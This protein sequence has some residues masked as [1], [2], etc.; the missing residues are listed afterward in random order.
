[1]LVPIPGFPAFELRYE[2]DGWRVYNV[3]TGKFLKGCE[4]PGRR[5]RFKLREGDLR[6]NKSLDGWLLHAGVTEVPNGLEIPGFPDYHLARRPDGTWGVRGVAGGTRRSGR[7]LSL[8]WGYRAGPSVSLGSTDVEHGTTTRSLAALVLEAHGFKRPRNWTLQIDPDVDPKLWPEGLA[9]A[10]RSVGRLDPN[11]VRKAYAL[12]HD[13]G[14]TQA[15]IA[16]RLGLSVSTV[17]SIARRTFYRR[18]TADLE[19]QNPESAA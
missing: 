4:R 2:A 14:L 18:H 5:K 11:I 1:V 13:S 6:L 12:Y 9:W 10:P 19:P 17:S 16:A 15:R 3:R 7:W 8:K